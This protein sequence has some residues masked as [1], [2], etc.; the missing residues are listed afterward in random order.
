MEADLRNP[1]HGFS[2]EQTHLALLR[3]IPPEND[4]FKDISGII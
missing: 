4:G 1:P 2:S 3:R